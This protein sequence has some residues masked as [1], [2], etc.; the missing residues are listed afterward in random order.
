MGKSDERAS[1]LRPG[2]RVRLGHAGGLTIQESPSMNPGQERQ[3]SANAPPRVRLYP[4]FLK[5]LPDDLCQCPHWGYVLKGTLHLRYKDGREEIARVGD[6]LV[7]ASG[8]TAWFDE[9]S[10]VCAG[11]S[12]P[13]ESSIR[14][15]RTPPK[16]RSKSGNAVCAAA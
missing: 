16:R 11:N 7:H 3:H 12:E 10:S 9:D 5:G 8:H 6:M 4:G 15:H 13:L 14:G 1:R 2:D